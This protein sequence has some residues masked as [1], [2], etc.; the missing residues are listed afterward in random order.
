MQAVVQ[1]GASQYLVTPGQEL[2][3]DLMSQ[4]QGQLNLGQV[5]LVIDGASVRVGQPFIPDF[6]VTATV[7]GPVKGEK[8]RVSKFKAKSRYDKTIGF[9]PQYTKIK[10]DSIALASSAPATPKKVVRPRQAR[11]RKA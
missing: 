4:D 2:S 3:V 8:I 5:L 10:I 7:I 1:I 9:R 11:E 6:Q